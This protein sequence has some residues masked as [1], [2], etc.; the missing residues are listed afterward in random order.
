VDDNI[1]KRVMH[2]QVAVVLDQAKLAE[3]VHE[4]V[5]RERVDPTLAAKSS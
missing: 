5:D 3:F 2:L 4:D 1:Q